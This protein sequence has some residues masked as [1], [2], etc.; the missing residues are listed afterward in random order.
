MWKD[1]NLL[2]LPADSDTKY[3]TGLI[4]IMFTHE[5][6]LTGIIGPIVK[7]NNKICTKIELDQ[8]RVDLFKG[9][10]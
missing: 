2:D 1:K 7:S 4:E 9:R 6:R 10:Y 5:E 3:I 8:E